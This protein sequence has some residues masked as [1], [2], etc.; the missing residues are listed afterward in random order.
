MNYSYDTINGYAKILTMNGKPFWADDLGLSGGVISGLAAIEVIRPTGKTR[1]VMIDI[2]DGLY[3][4][5]Q[6]KQWVFDSHMNKDHLKFLRDKAVQ[7]VAAYDL[8][9]SM[10]D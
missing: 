2:G 6:A 10:M 5:V 9:F 8:L 1:D 4:K 3:K 7:L